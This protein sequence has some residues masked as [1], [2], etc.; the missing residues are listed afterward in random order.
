MGRPLGSKN[1]PKRNTLEF[2]EDKTALEHEVVMQK[3][4]AQR[5][6]REGRPPKV[7]NLVK[8]YEIENGG[9]P[10]GKS[11]TICRNCGQ[12][13]EQNFNSDRNAYSSHR[14]C[15]ECRQRKS[16]EKEKKLDQSGQREVQVANLPYKPFPAQQK[17]HDAFETHRFVVIAAGN[18]FGKDRCS[19][20]MGIKYFCECLNENRLV[21]D[22]DMVPSVFWWIIAPTEPMAQQNWRELKR[23]FP[24]DWVVSVSNSDLT[25]ETIA[26]GI[27]Q[28]RSGYDPEYLVGVGLD[29]VTLTEAA[30][31]RD[32]PATWAN[33]EARLGSPKR[34]RAKDRCG[35]D[36]GQ[37]KAI[38]NS[39]PLGMNYFYTM[40]KWGQENS[41][42][43]DSL[44]WS[45][46]FP[47]TDNP[48]NNESAMRPVKNKYGQTTYGESLRRRLGDR[49]YRQNYL[50]DFLAGDATVFKTFE[51]K[52]VV[53]LYSNQMDLNE[54]GRIKYKE[55]WQ[56]VIPGRLYVAGYDPA[57]GSS[58]DNPWFV[59]RD[60]E[61]NNVI[62]NMNLYGLSYEEQINKIVAYCKKYN[63]AV[64]YWLRTGHTAL[65]NKFAEQGIEEV[66]LDEQGGHKAEL[67]QKLEL[68]VENGDV[69]VLMDGSDEAYMMISQMKD[70]T[71]TTTSLGNPKYSNN[72]APHDDCVS[73]MY[74]AW[75]TYKVFDIPIF[76]CPE[77]RFI[78]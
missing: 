12:L 17:I 66:P 38:I 27:I 46:Q 71:Q 43:Y 16:K 20:M 8:D 67:V 52:C 19:N 29:L 23:Y 54:H 36:A 14:L 50:A 55:E 57:T 62:V 34:G 13:F 35:S 10:K 25:M 65:E 41:Q 60:S 44:W 75:S 28:V 2:K 24:K 3:K 31:F 42:D 39:S 74:A 45:G 63:Y 15:P 7:T 32:L 58:D 68:A 56:K 53:N 18:R 1:K 9:P 77:C 70:Y 61:T 22:P 6:A 37:G 11:H 72:Q 40:F 26:G 21:K 51:E 78:E 4:N 49:A 33:L 69:H 30:R 59:I 64:L 73:A 48:V 76:Y 47:W 5:R